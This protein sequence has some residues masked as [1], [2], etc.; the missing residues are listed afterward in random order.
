MYSTTKVKH[1]YLYERYTKT[2]PNKKS[3]QF[4]F[5]PHYTQNILY[6]IFQNKWASILILILPSC[7]IS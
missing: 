5:R 4:L 2:L 1:M 7:K 6:Y 3:K